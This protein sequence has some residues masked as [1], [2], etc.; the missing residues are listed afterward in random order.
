[1]YH[2]VVDIGID[3]N[4]NREATY[5]LVVVLVALNGH[6][7]TPI[8][9][10]FI[11]SLNAEERANII[12][13]NLI[14]LSENGINNIRSIT[15][16]G[17]ASNLSM[18]IKLGCNAKENLNETSFLHLISKEPIYV[19]PDACHMLKLVRNTFSDCDI[20]DNEGR[21]ISWKCL[22]K[23]VEL[24]EKENLYPG[25]KITRRHI[26]FHNE[27]MKVKLAAQVLS[28]R[29]AKALI[30]LNHINSEFSEVSPT[31]TF[32]QMFNNI[33]DL[34]IIEENILNY[35]NYIKSLQAVDKKSGVLIPI[36]QSP[37][38]TGFWGFIV[39]MN[40]TLHITKYLFEK[41]V[42]TYFL[43]YKMSQDHTETFF[44]S[45]RRMG[46]FNNNPTCLQFKRAYKKLMTHVHA[47]APENANCTVQDKTYILQSEITTPNVDE[48]DNIF[49]SFDHDYQSSN[50]WCWN[51]YNTEVVT[52]I[53]GVVIKSIKKKIKCD[54][55]PKF[56]G[57][58]N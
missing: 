58:R 5:A 8:S 11:R 44:S 50:S 41:K 26:D 1:K 40:S 45:I 19:V 54:V 43:S 2:G 29:V 3:I 33:F 18:I 57:Y 51:E 12:T 31:A 35:I 9:Y 4:D 53:A 30:F 22:E 34:P 46:G 16:D 24:Q 36:L 47:I 52:Y 38:K 15:F 32:C 27:K 17:A 21:I 37:K 6:L 13:N 39:G 23:L 42:I 28:A 7:K 55:L 10:Y 48:L 14:I 25:T 56:R 49:T 20:I